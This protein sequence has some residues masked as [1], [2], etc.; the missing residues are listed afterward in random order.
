MGVFDR[1]RNGGRDRTTGGLPV[2]GPADGPVTGDGTAPSAGVAPAASASPGASDSGGGTGDR[3]VR[4]AAWSS[5]PPIQ[6][7]LAGPGS[8][9]DSGFGGRLTTWQNPS[10]TGTLSHAVLDGAPGGLVRGT[11]TTS[12][13]PASGLELPSL[14]LPVAPPVDTAGPVPA[15][16]AGSRSCRPARA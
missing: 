10:F 8:V 3:V 11:A 7:A 2:T 16:R 1:L 15:G 4:S 13:L 5:M 12:A 14:S 9:A 6:R